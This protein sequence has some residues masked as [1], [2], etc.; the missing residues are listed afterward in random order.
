MATFEDS[1]SP[2]TYKLKELFGDKPLVGVEIGVYQGENALEILNTVNINKIYLVDPY[3][4]YYDG[5]SGDKQKY[6]N[7]RQMRKVRVDMVRRLK[8][9]KDKIKITYKKSEDALEV[10][11]SNLDFVY[12][13]GLH[14]YE[15]VIQD[16]NMYYDKLQLNG[17]IGGDDFTD[18][19]KGVIKAVKEFSK[20]RNLK[21][22]T[23]KYKS[24]THKTK[25]GWI[26]CCDWWMIKN[27]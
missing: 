18:S 23:K 5:N 22:H 10:V 16:M 6:R 15:C 26:E 24:V 12:I 13:D 2:F 27:E 17:L 19:Y 11:P 21:Y 3:L 9:Y 7:I 20:E 1:A 14:N 8:P 25:E 4:P